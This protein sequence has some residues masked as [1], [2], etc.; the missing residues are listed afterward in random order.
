MFSFRRPPSKLEVELSDISDKV[1]VV[2]YPVIKVRLSSSETIAEIIDSSSSSDRSSISSS[3]DDWFSL[4]KAAATTYDVEVDAQGLYVAEGELRLSILPGKKLAFR[5]GIPNRYV[6]TETDRFFSWYLRLLEKGREPDFAN[7]VQGVLPRTVAYEYL[8]KNRVDLQRNGFD[9]N[10]DEM[11]E[12]AAV[13]ATHLAER[14]LGPRQGDK[15]PGWEAIREMILKSRIDA[16]GHYRTSIMPHFFQEGSPQIYSSLPH[17][18]QPQRFVYERQMI[19]VPLKGKAVSEDMSAAKVAAAH[20]QPGVIR[21][22]WVL[23]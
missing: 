9:L 4:E 22:K 19:S 8:Q 16:M 2:A 1:E 3:P 13:L 10:K 11:G 23:P 17:G 20:P 14:F 6:G 12:Y 15:L 18:I 21:R 7:Y 5:V